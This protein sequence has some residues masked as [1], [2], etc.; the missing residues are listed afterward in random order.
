MAGIHAVPTG[1]HRYFKDLCYDGYNL[2]PLYFSNETLLLNMECEIVHSWKSEY[3]PGLFAHLMP[4][5]TLVRGIRV[6]NQSVRFAGTTGGFERFD[7]DGNLLQRYIKND[8]ETD[9]CLSHAFCPMPNGNTL[10]ICLEKKTN[11][12]AYARG[13]KPGTLPE[14]GALFEGKYHKGLYLDYLMEIDQDNNV[15]WEWHLW[16]HVGEGPDKFNLNY[17]LP[18]THGYFATVDWVHFNGVDYNPRTDQ[19]VVT[20]RNFGEFVVIDRKSGKITARWGNPV[21]FDPKAVAPSYCMDGSE[22]LFGP[23]NAHFL[24]NNNVQVFDNGCMRPQGNRSRVLEV[25]PT[26]GKQVWEYKSHHPYNFCS[27]YQ[28]SSQRLPNGNVLVCASGPGQ[29]FE[30]TGGPEPRVIW[31]FVCPWLMDGTITN[32]LDDTDAFID[33]STDIN[34]AF[35]KNM[36]HRVYRYGKDYPAFAGKDLSNA[37][38]IAADIAR[39]WEIEPYKSGM[40]RARRAPWPVQAEYSLDNKDA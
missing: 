22:K 11:E 28:S 40:A 15:V 26:T 27:P 29:I 1:L 35:F 6:P 32:M 34:K 10:V 13:R 37:R 25:D 12:E 30:V 5:G 20:C 4:D 24:D 18:P 21:T 38:P 2:F 36:I 16:D 33:N 7:W 8:H 19:V 17:I 9:E 14:E 39:L 31:E 3:M 23:H